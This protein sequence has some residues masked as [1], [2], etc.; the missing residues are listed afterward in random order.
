MK[1]DLNNK[2]QLFKA[3]SEKNR[4]AKPMVKIIHAVRPSND[5]LS[6]SIRNKKEAENFIN[7]LKIAFSK[8]NK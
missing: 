6:K 7:E 1:I 8:T 5:N 2:I 3:I 4:E